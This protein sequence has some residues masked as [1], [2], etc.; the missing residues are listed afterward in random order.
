MQAVRIW[1]VLQALPSSPHP[2]SSSTG[3]PQPQAEF[4]GEDY[5]GQERVQGGNTPAS[6]P[7]S[8]SLR[9]PALGPGRKHAPHGLAH[10]LWVPVT[11][12][13]GSGSEARGRMYLRGGVGEAL[14]L[15]PF[16]PGGKFL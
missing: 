6:Q 10:S 9:P 11:P 3:D 2:G 5:R 13:A 1:G 12:G 16:A 15:L 4:L 7:L 14:Q 8:V